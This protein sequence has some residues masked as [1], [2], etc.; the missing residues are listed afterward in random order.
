MAD[1][2]IVLSYCIKDGDS[3]KIYEGVLTPT[4]IKHAKAGDEDKD[5][6]TKCIDDLH[7]FDRI[8]TYYGTGFDLPFLRAR[9]IVCGLDFPVFGSIKHTDLYYLV[10]NKFKLSSRRLEN[11]CRVLLGKTQKTR[12]ENSFWRGAVRGD[13]KSLEYVL[14]HNR[15]DV[16]DL[17]LL[18]K[19]VIEF[20]LAKGVSI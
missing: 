7:Q 3:K 10:R 5:L 18:Y 20:S 4:Q 12:I 8:V 16:L 1:F 15:K 13:K 14:D 11:A 19:K 2:G 9:A 6:I 17:E